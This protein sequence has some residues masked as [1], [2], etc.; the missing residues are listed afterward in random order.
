MTAQQLFGEFIRHQRQER[1]ISL[2]DFCLRAEVDPSNWSKIERS[3]LAPPCDDE[4]LD[5][6]TGAL[7]FEK[8]SPAWHLCRDLAFAERGRVPSDIMSDEELV[9]KLPLFFRTI[10]DEKPDETELKTFAAKLRNS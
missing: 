4:Q 6:I 1:R 8:G 7:G 3:K 9:A 5:K 2:R 10:R